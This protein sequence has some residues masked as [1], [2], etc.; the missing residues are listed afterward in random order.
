M[1]A[2]ELAALGTATS[3][4]ASSLAFESSARRIG[5]LSLNLVRVVMA[6]GW[7]TLAAGVLRG[8]A[9]PDDA[10]A[11]RWGYLLASGVVGL[12][13]GDLCLFRAYALIGARRTMI[14]ST[15]GPIFAASLAW[16]FLDERIGLVEAL[17][18]A[19][20]VAGVAIAVRD[21]A[22]GPAD[23]DRATLARGTTL[24]VGGALGQASGLLLSRH[25]LAGYPPIAGT[26]IRMI[27]GVVGFVIV[28]TA[29]RWWPRVGAAVRDRRALGFTAVGA[30]FGP[31]LGVA[32]SLYAV[33]H[34]H[35]GVASAIMSTA[36]VL[37]IPVALVRGERVGPIAVVGSL[38]AVAGVVI[39][40]LA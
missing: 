11:T 38:A 7:L 37:I 6:L 40:T 24:A 34:A 19:V 35:A 29:S 31:C 9:L 32:A 30:L 13:L 3:W 20:I 1:Q 28:V 25:G 33:T 5:S 23:V 27:A 21:R 14:V 4:T 39:L 17:G 18:M 16:I 15:T 2:G 22:P 26:Q 12:V 8:R 10:D 36:P